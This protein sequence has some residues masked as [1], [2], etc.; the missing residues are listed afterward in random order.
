MHKNAW[1]Y[2]SVT[3]GKF[4]SQI[5]EKLPKEVGEERN[6]VRMTLNLLA[7]AYTFG[8]DAM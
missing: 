7:Q 4:M 1:D 3:A 8:I 6:V 2:D 5:Y